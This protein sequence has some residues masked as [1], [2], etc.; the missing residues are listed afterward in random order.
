MANTRCTTVLRVWK[1]I[2]IVRNE[3]GSFTR[4]T[5]AAQAQ[6]PRLGRLHREQA[7]PSF[8]NARTQ[9]GPWGMPSLFKAWS[10]PGR[11]QNMLCSERTQDRKRSSFARHHRCYREFDHVEVAERPGYNKLGDPWAVETERE[12]TQWNR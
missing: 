6:G 9:G 12:G 8:V 7:H 5:V 3:H 11:V 4:G 2:P 10:Q 1:T